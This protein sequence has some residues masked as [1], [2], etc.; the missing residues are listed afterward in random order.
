MLPVTDSHPFLNNLSHPFFSDINNHRSGRTY[1]VE[2]MPDYQI[3]RHI[4][5]E[6]DHYRCVK[7]GTRHKM[8]KV[9]NNKWRPN[10][11]V[12]HILPY[13]LYP[14][15]RIDPT[16]AVSLCCECDKEFHREFGVIGT[17]EKQLN[18]FIGGECAK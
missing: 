16:N 17:G 13:S 3:F 8:K 7:C 14:E 2:G 12:H 10:M 11:T 1:L 5:L 15:R 6:R 9:G 18:E 4:V